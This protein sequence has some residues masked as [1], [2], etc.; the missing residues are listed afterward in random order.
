MTIK[1][2]TQTAA[3]SVLR[4]VPA[5]INPI[6][7]IVSNRRQNK[8]VNLLFSPYIQIDIMY[9][10]DKLKNIKS[11][12]FENE[13]ISIIMVKKRILKTV[14]LFSR[15]KKDTIL[16]CCFIFMFY[17]TFFLSHFTFFM[18]M[19]LL[20]FPLLGDTCCNKEEKPDCSFLCF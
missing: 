2:K 3:F 10:P 15:K 14:I 9:N 16:I 7:I 11:E 8:N 5:K 20:L 17:F 12:L 18:Q 13:R 4:E 19:I 1:R 6:Y